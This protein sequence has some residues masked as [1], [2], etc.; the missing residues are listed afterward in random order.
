MVERGAVVHG[1]FGGYFN[2]DLPEEDKELTHVGPGT[3]CGEYFRRFWIPV[4]FSA[5]LR[6]LP[7][8]VKVLGEELVLF[9]DG[10]GNVGLLHLHCSHRGTS[11]EYGRIA[12]TGIICCYHGWHYDVDGKILD[13]PGESTNAIKERVFHGAYPTQ[14]F[15]G[16][17]FAYMGPPNKKP[18]LQ[19]FDTSFLPHYTHSTTIRN[20]V[21]CNWLQI[22]E[23]SMDPAHTTYLHALVTG[24][25]FTESH[26]E[27][28]TIDFMESP[29]GMVY[30]HT[31]R[32]G[33][34]VWV[35]MN[36]FIPPSIH[37]FA[38][39]WEDGKILKKFQRPIITLWTVP[40]DN[41]TSMNLGFRHFNE[42]M[43][44]EERA[45][46]NAQRNS[47]TGDG[48]GQTGARSYA[49][50][51][52]EPGDYEAQVSQRPIAIHKL[53]NL[54][55]T[56]RGISMMRRMFREGIR[57]VQRGEDPKYIYHDDNKIYP[58]YANDTVLHISQQGDTQA[59]KAL[60][61]ETG[62]KCAKEFLENHPGVP[63]VE[64]A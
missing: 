44:D 3:P 46:M 32:I 9:R 2:R 24:I 4:G 33:D 35:H 15:G 55:S 58:T 56:D 42:R 10:N 17:V 21:P 26:K 53:E 57:A 60:L 18:S 13:T 6:D 22:K 34:N 39:T 62:R 40:I 30:I 12:K 50:T 47:L 37:Q 28:G 8:R 19:K 27:L 54:G 36:D 59:D 7:V 38:A 23:N 25:Q 43:S 49:E 45:K 1:P 41:T 11:L 52:R 31:R 63:A 14:E 29:I 5:E 20:V 64:M 48:F 61:L 51:Q 16:L